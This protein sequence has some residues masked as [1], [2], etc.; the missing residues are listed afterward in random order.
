MES[1]YSGKKHSQVDYKYFHIKL[2]SSHK[3]E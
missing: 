1:E 3:N 2:N